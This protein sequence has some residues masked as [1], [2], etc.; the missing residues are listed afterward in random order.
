VL[1]HNTLGKGGN[2]PLHP[3]CRA[4]AM[5]GLPRPDTDGKGLRP[6]TRL[7]A[8]MTAP[9]DELREAPSARESPPV[10]HLPPPAEIP[11]PATTKRRRNGGARKGRHFGPRPVD[12]PRNAW[13]TTRT[14]PEFLAKVRA[15]AKAAGLTL[16]DYLHVQLGG[17]R[18]PRARRNPTELT[19]AL[20]QLAAQMGK[21]G[22]N[23]NQGARALNRI[24][25]AA[26]EGAG[27]D[28][29]ADLIAEMAELH[30]QAIEEQRECL[31]AV[32]R[33]LGMRPD[34]DY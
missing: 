10:I 24:A 1:L 30:W 32:M 29:L 13:L 16:S 5:S 23:L 19:K 15:D 3:R 31:A 28:R 34:D 17:K 14:T 18:S 4:A 33:N 27:R 26:E 12:D 22:G 21:P 6:F 11:P 25:I 2:P 9:P 8:A 7:C 20:A